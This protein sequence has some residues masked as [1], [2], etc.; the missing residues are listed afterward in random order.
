MQTNHD[1][2]RDQDHQGF[3]Q[4]AARGSLQVQIPED[5]SSNGQKNKKTKEIMEKKAKETKDLKFKTS[6]TKD[7]MDKR[8]KTTDLMD[9]DLMD[10][11]PN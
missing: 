4:P 8:Q 9:I 11:R 5:K 1:H 10:T 2:H 6:K 3:R 7:L